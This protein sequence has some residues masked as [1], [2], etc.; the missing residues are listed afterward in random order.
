MENSVQ[1]ILDKF[2]LFFGH[3]LRYT[4]LQ[5]FFYEIRTDSVCGYGVF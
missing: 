1:K 4:F 3:L 5:A 2:H